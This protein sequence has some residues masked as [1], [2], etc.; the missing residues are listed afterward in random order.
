MRSPQALR[1]A[2]LD[3]A[4][5]RADR[6]QRARRGPRDRTGR[7]DQRG[8]DPGRTGRHRR[9]GGPRQ[10]GGRRAARRRGG[11]RRWPTAGTAPSRSCKVATATAVARGDV[12]ATVTGPTRTLL[13]RRA[14]RAQPAQPHVRGGDPH[15]GLGGRAGRHEGDGA[16]H[17]QDHAGAADAG[18]V[19]GA[20]RRR[21][22][23][24]DGPVR[25]RHDQGQPQ[26]GGGQHRARRTG[27]SARRS[28]TCRCRWR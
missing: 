26:A 21:H 27:G 5:V 7:R 9:H 23:Q 13:D 10:R 4:E 17:P 18:E 24:A 20:G 22:Q 1:A 8:H 16:G 6:R 2:G 28:R 15:A 25:R 12:L 14:D 19:R 3:P 11:V